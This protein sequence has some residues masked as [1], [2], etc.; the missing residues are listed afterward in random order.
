MRT[1]HLL[2]GG[3]ALVI[4]VSLG[5]CH[6]YVPVQHFAPGTVV[7]VQVPL[8]SAVEGS[9][10]AP[11]TFS[12]EGSLVSFGDTLEV[13]VTSRQE[14]GAFREVI[15]LDTLRIE[16]SQIAGLDE[17]VFSLRRSVVL[18]A[19]IGAVAGG[20]ALTALGLE[21]G[22]GGGTPPPI[23]PVGTLVLSPI[24]SFIWGLTGW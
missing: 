12:V 14:Y 19:V 21:G 4:V 7:R 16:V 23:P 5:G 6:R 11:E 1:R 15:R 3:L 24:V 17:R 18:G 10:Q 2:D 22:G 8:T 20:L 13:E 9:T